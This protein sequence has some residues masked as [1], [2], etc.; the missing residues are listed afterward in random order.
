MNMSSKGTEKITVVQSTASLGDPHICSDSVG[1]L[2]IINN[3]YESLIKTDDAGRYI[4]S[5]AEEWTVNEDASTWIFN[6]RRGVKFHN[7]ETLKA[8][9]VVGT[10][11]RVLDPSIGGAFGTQGV[12][13][14]YLENA[15]ITVVDDTSVKI[16]TEEPMADLL[17]LLVAMPISPESELHKLPN[18][19]C[20]SGPYKIEEQGKTRTILGAHDAYWGGS[21]RYNEIHWVAV[22]NRDDRVDALLEG[23]ADII[24]GI[25]LQG[26]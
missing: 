19:Y 8:T 22:R 24:T 4:P 7:G 1:R 14:S 6:L 15:E 26:K 23:K 17:D 16:V 5:L 10:L 9:D 3:V 11:N 25:G 13:I 12:Y 18:E 2:S 21:S 20:G